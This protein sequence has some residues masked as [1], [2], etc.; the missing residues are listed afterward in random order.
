[1]VYPGQ[2]SEDTSAFIDMT[3]SLIESAEGLNYGFD[4]LLD[5]IFEG[6]EDLFTGRIT[7]QEAARIIQNRA[8]IYVSEQ[9][10]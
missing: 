8:S 2:I 5:I 4:P 3:L 6:L 7:V 10:G 1:M 9:I